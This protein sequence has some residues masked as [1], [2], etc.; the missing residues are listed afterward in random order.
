[1]PAPSVRTGRGVIKRIDLEAKSVLIKHEAIADYMPAMT[2][3]FELPT[4]EVA[5]S[6][7]VGDEITFS[8]HEAKD[9]LVLDAIARVARDG[10]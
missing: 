8:F 6:F 3:P 2:M 4:P 1:V 9:G 10:G 7:V 5:K